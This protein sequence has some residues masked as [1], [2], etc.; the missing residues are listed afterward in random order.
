MKSRK[1]QAD[2]KKTKRK[3]LN[4]CSYFVFIYMCSIRKEKK[5]VRE[6][7]SFVFGYVIIV[8]GGNKL[9]EEQWRSS[10]FVF[11]FFMACG[12]SLRVG[13]SFES[14][15]LKAKM[16]LL[17]LVIVV[18]LILT[19]EASIRFKLKIPFLLDPFYV[20]ILPGL[21]L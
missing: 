5:R 10:A 4:S 16:E 13:F 20:C 19:W 3:K 14:I 9:L 8:L 6:R 15:Y 17:C 12:E 11:F 18:V 21:A 1:L 2:M 7:Y